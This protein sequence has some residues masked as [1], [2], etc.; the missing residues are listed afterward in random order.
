MENIVNEPAPAY[1]KAFYSVAEYLEMEKVSL[2][3]H[4]YYRGEIFAM[5]GAGARHNV[6]FSNMIGELYLRLKGK[7]CKPL[8]SD[9][10]VHIP[11]NTLFTYP[12]ISIFCSDI[13]PSPEDADTAMQPTVLIEILSPSTRNYDRGGKFKLY[14]DIPSLKEYLLIDSEAIN[15]EVFRVNAAGHWELEEYKSTADRL[16]I[17]A[18]AA[19]IDLKDIY[20]GTKL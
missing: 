9:M 4:E 16:H 5:S 12:D 8:G 13:V 7:S 6:I 1:E 18:I 10:R 19:S 15:I 20:E 11:E 17:A 14:R 2:Q 3:K